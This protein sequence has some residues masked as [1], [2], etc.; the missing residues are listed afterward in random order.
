[1]KPDQPKEARQTLKLTQA[2]LADVLGLVRG[3]IINYENGYTAIP[4]YIAWALS[5]L[6]GKKTVEQ[7]MKGVAK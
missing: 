2:Q 1:M 5:G 3:T 4:S 6:I 7:R